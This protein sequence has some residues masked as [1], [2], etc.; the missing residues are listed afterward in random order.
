MNPLM[1]RLNSKG[2]KMRPDVPKSADQIAGTS[3]TNNPSTTQIPT[4]LPSGTAGGNVVQGRI[5]NQTPDFVTSTTAQ[6]QP[7]GRMTRSRTKQLKIDVAATT[8]PLPGRRAKTTQLKIPRQPEPTT[9]SVISTDSTNAA[10]STAAYRWGT[11]DTGIHPHSS[12]D[13]TIAALT[14]LARQIGATGTLV[15]FQSPADDALKAKV[16]NAF[17]AKQL[18]RGD[19]AHLTMAERANLLRMK[20][21]TLTPQESR[22]KQANRDYNNEMVFQ[23]YGRIDAVRAQ[24]R[25]QSAI[26]LACNILPQSPIAAQL[27]AGTDLRQL[28]DQ[29][30]LDLCEQLAQTIAAQCNMKPPYIRLATADEQRVGYD[31]AKTIPGIGDMERD[32]NR[33]S[34]TVVPY[35]DAFADGFLLQKAFVH[36]MVHVEHYKHLNETGAALLLARYGGATR[37][38]SAALLP[39]QTD[40]L[41]D[42]M[43]QDDLNY[44]AIVAL[45]ALVDR[46]NV[47]PFLNELE[48]EAYEKEMAFE[49]AAMRSNQF[50]ITSDSYLGSVDPTQHVGDLYGEIGR[51]LAQDLGQSLASIAAHVPGAFPNGQPAPNLI[52]VLQRME[53]L[54]GQLTFDTF[55]QVLYANHPELEDIFGADP[56]PD[57]VNILGAAFNAALTAGRPHFALAAGAVAQQRLT[58]GGLPQRPALPQLTPQQLQQQPQLRQQIQQQAQQYVTSATAHVMN[59]ARTIAPGLHSSFSKEIYADKTIGLLAQIIGANITLYASLPQTEK[60]RLYNYVQGFCDFANTT[61]QAHRPNPLSHRQ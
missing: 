35:D 50:N 38:G 61:F 47:N 56:R 36:E 17:Q 9:Q 31:Y 12:D 29:Q 7:L 13:E 33:T 39:P 1:G 26:E 24:Q 52:P 18:G 4:I 41:P 48:K 8:P 3:S 55:M 49:I 32:E 37:T 30:K 27:T 10:S 11:L 5:T 25:S 15:P 34:V 21:A 59:R 45:T 6:R 23:E 54:R 14:D 2:Q 60:Q 16:R 22:Q 58:A 43:T 44:A 42:G 28:S 53:A 40:P 46:D 51:K 19:L 57:D 20:L